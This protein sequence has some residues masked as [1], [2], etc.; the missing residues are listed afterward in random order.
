[1]DPLAQAE[2]QVHGQEATAPAQ[3]PA[4][5]PPA[6]SAQQP[7]T[8]AISG[9]G[10][11]AGPGVPTA[12]EALSV[13]DALASYGLDLRTQF[14]DDHAALQHLVMLAR[15]AASQQPLVQYGQQY[16]QHAGEFQAYLRQKQEQQAAQQ[17][18]QQ[19]W[20]K[21]PEYDPT[22]S[23][24]LTR[25]PQTGEIR[26]L[27]GEPPDLVQKYLAWAEHQRSFLDKFAQDPIQAIKPGIEQV[28]QDTAQRLMQQQLAAYQER[29]Q[30][31][32]FLA[33]NADWMFARD[34]QGQPLVN[35]A[36]QQPALS[37]LGQQFAGYVFEAERMGL[38][39]TASQQKYALAALQRDYL[40]AKYQQQAQ[41]AA[42][43]AA[44]QQ[45]L[46]QAQAGARPPVA[47]AAAAQPEYR[48]PNGISARGLQE[49][50]LQ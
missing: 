8:E 9:T 32:Q 25:D 44:K 31:E 17:A 40:A 42:G 1:M 7:A 41:P 21:A 38:G 34:A 45:F 15:Q 28:V 43:D 39:D 37:P 24:R 35:P 12:A 27:P 4:A 26:A 47:P 20:W 18:Q 30:A 2:S 13:R 46:Q 33:Q 10:T 11:G 14:Q 6:P 48:Q 19:S 5:P 3:P 23:R 49:L 36:T 29:Q 16:V 22:W 50:M